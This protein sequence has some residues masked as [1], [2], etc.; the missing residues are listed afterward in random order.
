LPEGAVRALWGQSRQFASDWLKKAQPT[1]E[2]DEQSAN[3]K[4]SA[5]HDGDS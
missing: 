2:V 1:S 4:D 3:Q 5:F